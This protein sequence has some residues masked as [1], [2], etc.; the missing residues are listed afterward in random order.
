MT[1]TLKVKPYNPVDAMQSDEEVAGFF[2]D[3]FG[4]DAEG[5]TLA[6]AMRFAVD[7]IGEA[8]T[9]RLMTTADERIRDHLAMAKAEPANPDR[10][11]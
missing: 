4:E 11:P 5:Q 10:A 8:R 9:A 1:E 6:R 7:S 3:C 2:A